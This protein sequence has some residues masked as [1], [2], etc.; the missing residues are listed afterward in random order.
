MPH[1]MKTLLYDAL[2]EQKL[3]PKDTNAVILGFAFL[4]NSDDERNTPTIPLY[5]LLEKELKSLIIH[6]PHIKKYQTYPITNNLT[7]AIRDRDA[8]I[9]VTK[10]Q[11]YYD[12]T[13]DQLKKTLNTPIIIDGRNVYDR[14]QA[15]EKGFTFRGVG[16]PR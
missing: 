8:V 10:H 16:L 14:H 7:E 2:D 15:L 9:L 5:Y 11:E 1:H 6:D 3:A 13:L 4:E 12:L